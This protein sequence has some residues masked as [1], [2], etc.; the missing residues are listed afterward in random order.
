[1][2]G[3]LYDDVKFQKH[4]VQII[5]VH[6]STHWYVLVRTGTDIIYEHASFESR[7]VCFQSLTSL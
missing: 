7:S 4:E 3:I 2:Q 5:L 1:M 6:T